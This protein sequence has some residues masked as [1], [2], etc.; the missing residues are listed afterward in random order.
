MRVGLLENV[1]CYALT[2]HYYPHDKH[3]STIGAWMKK[4]EASGFFVRKFQNENM[5]SSH[6]Q[7]YDRKN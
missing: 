6:C 5:K 2:R 7:K 4:V 1:A 3:P